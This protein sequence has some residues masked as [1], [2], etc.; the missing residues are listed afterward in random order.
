MTLRTR[1]SLTIAAIG[2]ILVLPAAY[3]LTQLAQLRD[4]ASTQRSRHGEANIALGDLQTG[5][6]ELDRLQRSYIVAADTGVQHAMLLAVQA[7]RRHLERM[8]DAGYPVLAR[9]ASDHVDRLAIATRRLELLMQMGRA[10]EAASFFDEVRALHAA[11]QAVITNIGS[12]IDTRSASDIQEAGRISRAATTTALAALLFSVA[13]AALIGIWTT[14]A[15]S[16]PIVR[17]RD[18]MAVVA[19]GRFAVPV[20]L[21]Y[22]RKD[23]IGS[24]ARSFRAMTHRLAELDRM[25]AEFVSIATHE[26]R[27]PLN[28]ISGY[29]ELLSDGIYGP[30]SAAQEQALDAI[31]DQSRVL[32]QLVNQLLDVSRFEAGGL[33]L[34]IRPE[35]TSDLFIRIERAFGALAR[36]KGIELVIAID[37]TVPERVPMDL[38]RMSDQVLGNLL[39]NALKFTSEGGRITVRAWCDGGVLGIQVSDT[40]CGIPAAQLPHVFE[41]FYQVGEDARAQGTGLGLAIAHEVVKAHGGTIAA[42]SE[43]GR[44]STFTVS[45]P[46]DGA[47]TK[48]GPGVRIAPPG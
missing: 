35:L 32:A 14:H 6:S 25:K 11:A 12:E 24:T 8:R 40:G 1:L 26:L 48:D 44:G 13:I 19:D 29:A 46:L 31:R 21:A 33:S 2:A 20:N 17:L 42:E 7:S 45:I 9:F 34:E 5:L 37:D 38:D 47:L 10:E 43:V 15:L 16:Q 41:K 22:G 36:R 4:I 23:E 27:T 39:S 30:L 3:G 18:A 28:V